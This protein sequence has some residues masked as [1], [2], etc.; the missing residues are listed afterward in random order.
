[1]PSAPRV[2]CSF[3]VHGVKDKYL[4]WDQIC[5]WTTQHMSQPAKCFRE[6]LA[7][8]D[9]AVAVSGWADAESASLRKRLVDASA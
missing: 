5:A 9:A 8:F 7:A 4:S 1:M 2:L 3:L 6:L